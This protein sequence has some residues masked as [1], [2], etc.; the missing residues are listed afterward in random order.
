MTVQEPNVD[1]HPGGTVRE[2]IKG[3]ST[4]DKYNS[5]LNGDLIF[6]DWEDDGQINHVRVE[7]G[8]GTP[9][10]TG[11]IAVANHSDRTEGDW[12]D[13]H[14][15]PR[16]KDFCNGAYRLTAGERSSPCDTSTVHINN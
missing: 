8:Y 9:S 6:F 2:N 15:P 13:Q 12:L 1:D 7:T 5:L 16:Y 10:A 4:S 14:E 3:A 11:Y